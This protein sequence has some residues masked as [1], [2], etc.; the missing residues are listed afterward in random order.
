MLDNDNI[1]TAKASEV[2]QKVPTDEKDYHKCSL[3]V[4]VSLDDGKSKSF[5]TNTKVNGTLKRHA[6]KITTRIYVKLMINIY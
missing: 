4:I 3:C 5:A 6:E 2:V 1:M